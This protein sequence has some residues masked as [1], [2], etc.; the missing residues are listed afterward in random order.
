MYLCHIPVLVSYAVL[1]KEKVAYLDKVQFVFKLLN[2]LLSQHLLVVRL[3]R[4][5]I[6]LAFCILV[7]PRDSV[8]DISETVST[9]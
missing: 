3:C 9:K 7:V 1:I 4:F 6:L 8:M 5:L 2:V